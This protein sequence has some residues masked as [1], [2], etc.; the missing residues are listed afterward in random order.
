MIFLAFFAT[1][2]W[3]LPIAAFS[4]SCRSVHLTRISTRLLYTLGKWRSVAI[5]LSHYRKDMM[6]RWLL[7]RNWG[8]FRH[9]PLVSQLSVQTNEWIV[10]IDIS[11]SMIFWCLIVTIHQ[12]KSDSRVFGTVGKSYSL[13]IKIVWTW[14]TYRKAVLERPIL[15]EIKPKGHLN[16]PSFR[17][18]WMDPGPP[19][20]YPYNLLVDTLPTPAIL[21]SVIVNFMIFR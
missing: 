11:Q 1:V 17:L 10:F 14:S 7:W 13:A 4:L 9:Y 8:M 6:E 15:S 12:F 19:G 18:E 3:A 20:C 5:P 2:L 16:S 21:R